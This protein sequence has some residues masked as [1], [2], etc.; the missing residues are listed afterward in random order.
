[1]SY[2]HGLLVSGRHKLGQT[3]NK[4]YI[5]NKSKHVESFSCEKSAV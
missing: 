3:R 4:T 1:M 5:K 2:W